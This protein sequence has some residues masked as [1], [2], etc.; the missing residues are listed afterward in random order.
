[1]LSISDF[2]FNYNDKFFI[3]LEFPEKNLYKGKDVYLKKINSVGMCF[4]E[5]PNNS[6]YFFLNL[7]LT[8]AFGFFIWYFVVNF[9]YFIG[10]I[11]L[12]F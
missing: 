4:V 7:N 2:F 10:L 9:L 6:K 5:N 11:Y 3:K 12:I 1:M 8:V